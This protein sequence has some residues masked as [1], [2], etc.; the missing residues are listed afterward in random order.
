MKKP[1]VRHHTEKTWIEAIHRL[2]AKSSICRVAVAYCGSEAYRFFP[3]SP[4]ARPEGLR[5]VVDASDDTVRRGLT[6]P[7]G[8]EHLLGLTTQLRTLAALHAKVF[9]F[10][11]ETALVGS[12]NMSTA[13]LKQIQV[14]VEVR[15]PR[16]VRSLVQWFDRDVW[17]NARPLSAEAVRRLGYLWP[18]RDFHGSTRHV[19]VHLPKWHGEVPQPPLEPSDFRVSVSRRRLKK[20]LTQFETNTCLY[21]KYRN[22]S[23]AI[24]GRKHRTDLSRRQ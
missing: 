11:D 5:L 15:N 17:T 18:S 3:E 23:C 12:M 13:S 22:V 1:G 24:A 16:L 20:L 19:K 6:N 2:A 9:I 7:K 8:L 10:D 4:A 21:P 14:A